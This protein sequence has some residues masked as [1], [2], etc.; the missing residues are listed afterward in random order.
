MKSPPSAG[1]SR[2]KEGHSPK[3][4]LGW[5]GREGSNLRMG[6]SKS[7]ALPLGYA[8]MASNGQTTDQLPRRSRLRWRPV[9]RLEA[10]SFADSPWRGGLRA[11][12]GKE[13]TPL[14]HPT[15]FLAIM[16][17]P[18]RVAKKKPASPPDDRGGRRSC[19]P[20]PPSHVHGAGGGTDSGCLV[21]PTGGDREIRRG[22]S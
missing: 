19:V 2:T 6:E 13:E 18:S 11:F 12:S 20:P 9:F 22:E 14:R 17:A 7:T 21:V 4:G 16:S 5:L 3:S 1:F 8:P 15:I 10:A